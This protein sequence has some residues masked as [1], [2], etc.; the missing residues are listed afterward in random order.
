MEERLQ[1][2]LSAAGVCS[3]R[4]SERYILAGRV[5]VNG[6]PAVLGQQADPEKDDI[7]V[8]GVSI[9]PAP[10]LVYLMLNKPRGYVTTLSDEQGRPTVAQLVSDAGVRVYPVGRLDLD[11][12]GLLLLTNDG[13]LTHRLLHPSHEI[14]KTYHVWVYGPVE[15]AAEKLAAIRDLRGEPIQAADVR[16]LH[17]GKETAEYAI[18]IHE[19]KNRQIRRMCARCDLKVKRLRRVREHTL[20]LGDLP[21]GKWRYLTEE[22]VRSLREP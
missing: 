4:A 6:R 7:R 1:K 21:L 5:S 19:G 20:E 10:R 15:G 2:I 8:D 11:S 22:E 13:A 14:S 16:V 9:R 12:E 18:T 17:Q 3:R